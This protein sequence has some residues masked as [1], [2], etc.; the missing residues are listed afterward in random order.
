[1][2]RASVAARDAPHGR[3][4]VFR[5]GR[6]RWRARTDAGAACRLGTREARS[7]R[8]CCARC[9]HALGPCGVSSNSAHLFEAPGSGS[10]PAPDTL[11]GGLCL[12]DW[13]REKRLLALSRTARRQARPSSGFAL[14]HQHMPSVAEDVGVRRLVGPGPRS[15]FHRVSTNDTNIVECQRGSIR[16]I[17][18]RTIDLSPMRF[19]PRPLRDKRDTQHPT[20]SRLRRMRKR[21]LETP[22]VSQR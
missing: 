9:R 13:V 4:C 15:P 6:S 2:R 8:L 20:S 1:M 7:P 17:P 3:I 16:F 21:D 5:L 11:Y 14:P 18:E 22:G 10:P 12:D 19:S